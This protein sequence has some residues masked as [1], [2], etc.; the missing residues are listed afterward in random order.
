MTL[1]NR[2]NAATQQNFKTMGNETSSQILLKYANIEKLI[3][4]G[5]KMNNPMYETNKA[6]IVALYKTFYYPRHVLTKFDEI[7]DDHYKLRTRL[8]EIITLFNKYNSTAFDVDT[9]VTNTYNSLK[10]TF[11]FIGV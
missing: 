2:N 5:K 3:D 4:I 6:E 11:V 10:P 7:N 9:Y 1:Y 8:K